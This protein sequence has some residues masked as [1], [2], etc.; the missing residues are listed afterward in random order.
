MSSYK[1]ST[2]SA[3]GMLAILC[4][5]F[6]ILSGVLFFGYGHEFTSRLA[7]LFNEGNMAIIAGLIC[8][9][10]AVLE[11]LGGIIIYSFQYYKIGG[12]LIL[13]I[14]SIEA[15][16]YPFSSMLPVIISPMRNSSSLMVEVIR[17]CQS[18]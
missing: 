9:I 7:P 18:R 13:L 14:S 16:S 1:L 8:V 15:H 11:I 10:F 5:I 12:V 6:L 2:A 4:G 17:S 3:S